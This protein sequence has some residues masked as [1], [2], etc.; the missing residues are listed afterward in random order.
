VADRTRGDAARVG[1]LEYAHTGV[2]AIPCAA[3]WQLRRRPHLSVPQVTPAAGSQVLAKFDGTA[4]AVIERNVGAGRVLLW[5]SALDTSWSDLPQRSVFVPFIHQAMR[6]LS[7]YAEPRPW[8]NVGQ[9]LDAS[10]AA[11]KKDAAQRVV[12]TP[13]G[14]RVPLQDEGSEVMELSDRVL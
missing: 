11:V 7:A 2:R 10:T 12:L 8:L 13:S 6:F 3:Q 9:V 1:A 14:K 5:A 4:P